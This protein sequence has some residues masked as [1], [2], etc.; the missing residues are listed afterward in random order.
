MLFEELGEVR[1]LRGEDQ[2]MDFVVL[3][4]GHFEC[5]VGVVSRG[6]EPGINVSTITR[7]TR[8]P[9]LPLH[10]VS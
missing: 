4:A 7:R 8:G 6:D 10:V 2:S 5:E 3:S 9:Y 1:R